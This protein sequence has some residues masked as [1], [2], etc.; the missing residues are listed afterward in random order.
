VAVP[1]ELCAKMPAGVPLEAAS[2]ST[3]AAI[4]MHGVRL[5]GV[6]L[7]ERFAVVGCGLVGQIAVR[8][9][10]AAGAAVYALDLDSAKVDWAREGGAD[11]AFVSRPGAAAEVV[12]ASGG[13][14][15]DAV[16]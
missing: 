6:A 2:L 7:G 4:A 5:A 15:V 8:L 1:R 13:S 14:G 12:G 16:R 11:F 3:I 10:R 9:L